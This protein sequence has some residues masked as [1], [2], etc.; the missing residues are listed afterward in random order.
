METT[1]RQKIQVAKVILN[2]LVVFVLSTLAYLVSSFLLYL[3]VSILLSIPVLS[4]ITRFVIVGEWTVYLVSIFVATIASLSISR[5]INRKTK[6]E[7]C[8]GK[9]IAGAIHIAI[10]AF[11]VISNFATGSEW[12]WGNIAIAALGVMLIMMREH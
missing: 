10:G 4:G 6:K 2:V 8:L 3:L 9:I 11:G 7:D 12:S 5:T 1:E